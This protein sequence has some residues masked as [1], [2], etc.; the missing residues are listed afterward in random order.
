M[1]KKVKTAILLDRDG[2]ISQER[3]DYVKSVE[4]FQFID[5]ALEGVR[6]LARLNFPVVVITNQSVVGRGIISKTKLDEIHSHMRSKIREGGGRLDA[7]FYC[8]HRP[9]QNC[10]CR[11]PETEL[12]EKAANQFGFYLSESWF[13][14]DKSIDEEAGKKVGCRTLRIPTNTPGAFLRA[15]QYIANHYKLQK[16]EDRVAQ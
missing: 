1:N 5:G 16:A 4:E 15:A 9:S 10:K 7:I 3:D 8:P 2:V 14:G 12:F 6:V 11:K 13:I